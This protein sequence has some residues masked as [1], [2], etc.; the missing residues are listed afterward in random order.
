[1]ATNADRSLERGDSLAACVVA[2]RRIIRVL[3][4]SNQH[5]QQVSGVSSA[6]MFVLQELRDG[7]PLSLNELAERTLTD[8]TSVAEVVTRLQAR[9]LI[10]RQ[11]AASDRRR[12]EITLTAAGR[13]ILR[14]APRNIAPLLPALRA[15][16]KRDLDQLARHLKVVTRAMGAQSATR[17]FAFEDASTSRG[18]SKPR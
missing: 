7:T 17:S 11:T 5:T 3:R 4:L 15:L 10:R 18:R 1:M 14:R 16:D 9:R 13:A 6:Q 12:A 2:F 8:R